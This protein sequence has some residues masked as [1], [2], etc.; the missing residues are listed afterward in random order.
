M[1]K[2]ST[3]PPP[4]PPTLPRC[5]YNKAYLYTNLQDW[6]VIKKNWRVNHVPI[7]NYLKQV[8]KNGVGF[9]V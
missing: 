5:F 9:L 7:A 6:I 2:N 8:I 3:S 1:E 4:P